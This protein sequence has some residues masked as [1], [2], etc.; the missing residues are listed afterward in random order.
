MI[1]EGTEWVTECAWCKRVRDRAG[2]WHAAVPA[3]NHP[4]TGG[5]RTHGVCPKCAEGLLA[6]ADQANRRAR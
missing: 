5:E 4:A 2:D 3:T 1:V 6:R